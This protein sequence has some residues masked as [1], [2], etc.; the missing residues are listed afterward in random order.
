MN[1]RNNINVFISSKNRDSNSTPYNYTCKLPDDLIR[2]NQ[3]Q[4]IKINI[5]SFDMVNSMYNINSHN[6]H[7]QLIT[8]DLNGGSQLI[9]NYYIPD[10]NYSVVDLKNWIN[11]NNNFMIITYNTI[12]N[13][14]TFV[15]SNNSIKLYL[16][17]INSG[18]F[19]G[20]DNGSTI[21]IISNISMNKLNIVYSNK[22]IIRALNLNF[23][24]ES[25][26]NINNTDDKFEL[27]NILLWVSKNDI[28]PFQV[29]S[30]N[31]Y[32]GGNSYSY[33]LYNKSIDTI[34]FLITNEFNE[35]ITDLPDWTMSCQFSIYE[36][37]DD[38]MTRLIAIS[39]NYLREIYV[40][41]HIFYSWITGS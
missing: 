27:S 19:L 34:H 14:Y 13:K 8:T 33:N 31:N 39:N 36:R 23:E 28:A 17:I 30:Y 37:K 41:L 26:E 1:E 40:F 32:D 15:K 11:S 35:V 20:F 7:F 4:G 16:N 6:N 29:I 22:I 9:Y 25:L 12:T 18:A 24:I 38:E 3:S 5:I 21:E 10:G 2:C